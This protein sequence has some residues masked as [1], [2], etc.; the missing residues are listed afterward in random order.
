MV[1]NCL[2][3]NHIKKQGEGDEIVM[4]ER[5]E[6]LEF[7]DKIKIIECNFEMLQSTT[8]VKLEEEKNNYEKATKTLQS[9]FKA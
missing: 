7:Y 3:E 4:V 9:K 5:D 2:R 8:Q 6:I 1:L